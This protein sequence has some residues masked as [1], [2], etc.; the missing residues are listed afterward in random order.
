MIITSWMLVRRRFAS[1]FSFVHDANFEYTSVPSKWVYTN[2]A[3]W[4][5]FSLIVLC[6]PSLL[7]FSL[8]LVKS[9]FVLA[10]VRASHIT[11]LPSKWEIHLRRLLRWLFCICSQSSGWKMYDANGKRC[12]VHTHTPTVRQQTQLC[13]IVATATT[14]AATAAT[15]YFL[16]LD[17]HSTW[18]ITTVSWLCGCRHSNTRLYK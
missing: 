18:K 4:R 13:A 11:L 17:T 2:N 3:R 16:S 8:V 7:L 12:L 14:A 10:R 9:L 6:W 5:N 15:I 1:R